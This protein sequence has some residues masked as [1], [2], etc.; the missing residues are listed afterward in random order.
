MAEIHMASKAGRK[1]ITLDLT[2]MVDLGFILITFF[3]Y[4]TT[5]SIPKVIDIDMPFKPAPIDG[6]TAYADTSTITL[7]PTGNNRIAY[8]HGAFQND[9]RI[10]S[11]QALRAI[12]ITK[13]QQLKNLPASFSANAHKLHIIIKPHDACK[14]ET[15][16]GLIDEMS[17]NAIPYY[18][19]CDIE[20]EEKTLVTN[21]LQSQPME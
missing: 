19:I 21:K 1:P 6:G 2:P 17:I 11:I 13:Q 15:L 8:Y 4:T 3:I 9:V 18:A 20:T 14:Y 10:T 16:V 7:I 12:L 5:I